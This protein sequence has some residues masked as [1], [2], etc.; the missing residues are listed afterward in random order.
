MN[1]AD[2]VNGGEIEK[3]AAVNTATLGKEEL[4]FW[5]NGEDEDTVEVD[6]RGKSRDK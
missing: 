5:W 4:F 6:G 2:P 3:P 1:N